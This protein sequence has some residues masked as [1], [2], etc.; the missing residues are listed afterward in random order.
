MTISNG[1]AKG[2]VKVVGGKINFKHLTL[3][4]YKSSERKYFVNKCHMWLKM[5]NDNMR[6][7]RWNK[8]NKN[9]TAVHFVAITNQE[10]EDAA[11]D[12]LRAFVTEVN[13]NYGTD[14]NVR[15]EK[16]EQNESSTNA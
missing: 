8:P 4:L 5:I 1:T 11:L 3:A 2:T 13:R 12:H 15:V 14:L 7:K 10:E 9:G 16:E 6:P